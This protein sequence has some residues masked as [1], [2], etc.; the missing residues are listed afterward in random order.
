MGALNYKYNLHTDVF[1]KC[2][3]DVL[4]EIWEWNRGQVALLE[5]RGFLFFSCGM[6]I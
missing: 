3:E 1:W 6:K 5:K 4:L 2:D